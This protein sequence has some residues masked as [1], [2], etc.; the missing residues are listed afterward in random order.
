MKNK[1]VKIKNVRERVRRARKRRERKFAFF[2]GCYRE[3]DI[4]ISGVFYTVL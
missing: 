4:F 3:V 1:I 2:A